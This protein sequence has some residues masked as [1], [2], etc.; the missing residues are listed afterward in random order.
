VGAAGLAA[1]LTFF[2]LQKK[3]T[4]SSSASGSFEYDTAASR[5]VSPYASFNQIGVAGTF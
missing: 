1:G 2:L 5:T 4:N 3:S